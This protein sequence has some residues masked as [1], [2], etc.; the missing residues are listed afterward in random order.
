MSGGS[1]IGAGAASERVL[2]LARRARRKGERI[3]SME[4]F[5]WSEGFG[6]DEPDGRGLESNV[7]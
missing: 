5:R 1:L 7:R 3:L 6:I 2:V 4:W